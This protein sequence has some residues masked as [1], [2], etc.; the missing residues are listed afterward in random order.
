MS[1]VKRLWFAIR[2]TIAM[3]LAAIFHFRIGVEHL[4]PMATDTYTG[5]FSQ[6]AAAL[7]TLVPVAIGIVLVASWAY[8]V[9][10]PVQEEKKRVVRRP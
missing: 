8:V 4:Y 1:Q 9:F 10:G 5:P 6:Y 2:V 3:G 7:E